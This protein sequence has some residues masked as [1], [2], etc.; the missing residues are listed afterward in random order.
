MST[1]YNELSTPDFKPGQSNSTISTMDTLLDI[2]GLEFT[3]VCNVWY[4]SQ[5]PLG[6]TYGTATGNSFTNLSAGATVTLPAANFPSN[7]DVSFG[8]ICGGT[9]ADTGAAEGMVAAYVV[10]PENSTAKTVLTPLYPSIKPKTNTLSSGNPEFTCSAAGSLNLP[11]T[12]LVGLFLGEPSSNPSIY[13]SSIVQ[14]S[15][16]FQNTNMRT[17][18]TWTAVLYLNSHNSSAVAYNTF[19]AT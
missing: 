11:N 12:A 2:Q 5:G 16:K 18:E 6:N 14:G 4:G 13:L 1:E 10:I 3:G 7:I 17:G 15:A 19:I 8:V 9:D